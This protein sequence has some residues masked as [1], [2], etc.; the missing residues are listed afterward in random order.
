MD[1]PPTTATSS[2]HIKAHL[3]FGDQSALAFDPPKNEAPTETYASWHGTVRDASSHARPLQEGFFERLGRREICRW[4]LS[5]LAAAWVFLQFAE[6]LG[7]IWPIGARVQ[8]AVSLALLLGI[9][10]CLV[11]AWF[12][13]EQGRQCVSRAEVALLA[14]CFALAGS[15]LWTLA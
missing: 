11:I 12:H 5:Y 4:T 2:R 3:S 14:A 6:V 10:P 1:T 9:L 15:V 8:Q 7:D 13:G